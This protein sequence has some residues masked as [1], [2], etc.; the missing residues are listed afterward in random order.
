MS[1]ADRAGVGTTLG[2]NAPEIGSHLQLVDELL[3]R[4][5]LS[6]RAFKKPPR[7]SRADILFA[8]EKVWGVGG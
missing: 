8:V 4:W 6:G 3:G 5:K 1:N 2:Q 7:N